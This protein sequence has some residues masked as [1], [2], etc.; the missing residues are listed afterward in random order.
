M[1]QVIDNFYYELCQGIDGKPVLVKRFFTRG[2]YLILS[3]AL[4]S[5]NKKE[6]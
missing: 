4:N 2:E 6:D 1:E 3:S 5:E